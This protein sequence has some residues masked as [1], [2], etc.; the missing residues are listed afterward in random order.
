MATTFNDLQMHYRDGAR[1]ALDKF[2]AMKPDETIYAFALYTDDDCCATCVAANTEEAL[3]RKIAKETLRRKQAGEP[4]LSKVDIDGYRWITGEWEYE[5]IEDKGFPTYNEMLSMQ[6]GESYK[7]FRQGVIVAMV[8]ALK[9]LDSEG[10]FGKGTLRERITLF[11]AITDSNESFLVENQS[12]RQLNPRKVAQ[13]FYRRF[14]WK[15]RMLARV[16][17]W[18]SRFKREPE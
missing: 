17:G 7:S 9:E 2:R 13:Q 10:V 18:A 3:Q 14:T 5:G 6:E 15:L 11:V 4:D 16:A 1:F 8:G 12:A